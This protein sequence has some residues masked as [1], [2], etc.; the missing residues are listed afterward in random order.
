M[1]IPASLVSGDSISWDDN[2]S[3][4]NLGNA[5]DSSQYTLSYVFKGKGGSLT[6]TAAT[7]GLGWRTTITTTQSA[8]LPPDIYYWQAY[9]TKSGARQTLG[10]GQLIIKQNLA[11]APAGFD[12][13]SQAQ[14]DLDAVQAAI[15][16]GGG[17]GVAE[18]TI[19]NR[20]LKNIPIADLMILESQLK[21]QVQKE[22]QAEAI[23]NGLGNPKNVFVRFT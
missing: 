14:K 12:G 1:N 5:V 15:R 6:V 7:N 21:A 11:A 3:S 8:T 16:K 19:G 17:S 9:A 10:N 2:G 4:D 23:A 13:R 22:K 20:S 18:Y